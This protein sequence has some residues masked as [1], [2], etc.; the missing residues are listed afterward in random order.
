M[1]CCLLTRTVNKFVRAPLLPQVD[2]YI[3]SATE[4]LVLLA[5]HSQVVVLLELLCMLAKGACTACFAFLTQTASEPCLAPAYGQ[6]CLSFL[7]EIKVCNH[8]L[9][10]PC[11]I[12]YSKLCSNR[13]LPRQNLGCVVVLR[14]TGDP[15]TPEF[16]TVATFHQA[17]SRSHELA[18]PHAAQHAW[19]GELLVQQVVAASFV[20]NLA[21]ACRVADAVCRLTDAHKASEIPEAC[22]QDSL[23][24]IQA[25]HVRTCKEVGC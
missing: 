16:M 3:C 1:L 22:H 19:A 5:S 17:T 4:Q 15:P 7:H 18:C 21:I 11:T 6:G 10:M 20:N 13:V 12:R 8:L 9:L 25:L 14:I 2:T 23:P 24:G